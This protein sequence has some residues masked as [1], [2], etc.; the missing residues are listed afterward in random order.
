MQLF[1]TTKYHLEKKELKTELFL[2]ILNILRYVF[3]LFD[4][5]QRKI[6]D[7][8]LRYV[9]LL[10]NNELQRLQVIILIL[11]CSHQFIR[12]NNFSLS[13]LTDMSKKAPDLTKMFVIKKVHPLPI[14]LQGAY[15]ASIQVFFSRPVTSTSIEMSPRSPIIVRGSFKKYVD[16][17]HN[18]FTRRHI[19]L[20]F[21]THI[22]TTNSVDLKEN[23]FNLT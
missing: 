21:G 3:L 23:F 12:E 8:K 11:N 1:K 10:L 17:Y 15:R 9:F 18:F 22:W 19:T 6:Q 20:R 7:N 14:S 2:N 13:L 4:N 16:F 5:E